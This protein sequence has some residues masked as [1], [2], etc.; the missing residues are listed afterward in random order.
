MH[1][2]NM[3]IEEIKASLNVSCEAFH[4][5][6][7]KMAQYCQDMGT[8]IFE[9]E[10][11]LQMNLNTVKLWVK[12]GTGEVK[13]ELAFYV[14]PGNRK[15]RAF[16]R[17][18]QEELY[19]KEV[20][21]AVRESHDWVRKTKKI[22]ALTGKEADQVFTQAYVRSYEEQVTYLEDLMKR[23]TQSR[24]GFSYTLTPN[25]IVLHHTGKKRYTLKELKEMVRL[26]EDKEKAND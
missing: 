17:A 3:T 24:L 7:K 16:S 4:E 5:S 9:L 1:N 12:V 15:L 21:V 22:T 2:I 6:C 23:K 26:L 8:H 19:G 11:G 13:P 14:C 18:Q 20:E 10:K 25:G